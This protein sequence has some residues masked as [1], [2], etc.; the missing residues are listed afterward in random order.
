MKRLLGK[1]NEIWCSIYQWILPISVMYL[2]NYVFKKYKLEVWNSGNY[3]DMLSALI[4]FISI[5]ISVLGLLIPALIS[6]K[7]DER[8]L[9]FLKL[10]NNKIFVGILKQTIVSGVGSILLICTLYLHDIIPSKVYL[11]IMLI[12]IFFVIF[13]V[14]G[15][16]RYIGIMFSLL[17]GDD[18]I[19][20]VTNGFKKEVS[21]DEM[22]KRNTKIKNMK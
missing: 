1:I 13:F 7:Q 18:K 20:D 9:K 10:A 4:T 22:K 19:K 2:L 8:V 15:A 17:M 21:A 11:K 16:Y 3:S 12:A 5:V 6:S 14:C